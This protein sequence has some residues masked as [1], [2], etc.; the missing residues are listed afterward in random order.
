MDGDINNEDYLKRKW[1]QIAEGFRKE[2][3]IDVDD[4]TYKGENF[5]EVLESLE[6]KT[7]KSSDEIKGEIHK[8]GKKD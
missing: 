5:A 4:D 1:H 2:Y 8:W 3:K 6:K 7:G